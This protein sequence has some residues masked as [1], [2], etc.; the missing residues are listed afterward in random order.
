VGIISVHA[1]NLPF[2]KETS[3]P[4]IALQ[5]AA[6]DVVSLDAH[7]AVQHPVVAPQR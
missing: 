7:R 5:A 4:D 6:G 2:S 1:P 3:D